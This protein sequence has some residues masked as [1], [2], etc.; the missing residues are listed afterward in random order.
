M[1][2]V[3]WF[4]GEPGQVH[5]CKCAQPGTPSEELEK[6]SAVFA[7]RAVST[8]HSPVDRGQH[9]ALMRDAWVAET[10]AEAAEVYGP[11][12]MTAYRYYW[13]NGLPEFHGIGSEDEIT[14]DNLGPDR[15]ILGEPDECVA[16]FRRW[17]E[18]VGAEYFLLRLRHAHSGGPPH[19]KIMEA[20]R[21]FGEEVIPACG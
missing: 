8:Q 18:A 16:E 13:R 17:S 19:E 6:F 21:L 20:I 7:G 12:V 4:L 15:L 3:L 5:A 11:E 9:P 2:G 1:V 10:R 14:L